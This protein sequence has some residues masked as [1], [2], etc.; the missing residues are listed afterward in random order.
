MELL[1]QV[2]IVITKWRWVPVCAIRHDTFIWL[3]HHSKCVFSLLTHKLYRRRSGHTWYNKDKERVGQW[4]L[5][6]SCCFRGC[7]WVSW[8]WRSIRWWIWLFSSATRGGAN[9][10]LPISLGDSPI[11]IF[12]NRFL[13]IEILV[14]HNFLFIFIKIVIVL[15][16]PVRIP[17]AFSM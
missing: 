12:I 6:I 17:D 8:S 3:D 16:P 4:P 15:L 2:K 13:P 5:H 1:Q 10:Q 7:S 14:F 9:G 11:V